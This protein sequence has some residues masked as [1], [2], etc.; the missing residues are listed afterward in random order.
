M[1]NSIPV[2]LSPRHGGLLA[3]ARFQLKTENTV[4]DPAA[5]Q[6]ILGGC[7][8]AFSMMSARTT[9]EI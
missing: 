5:C 1:E 4:A 8:N 3:A 6:R 2:L 7:K 9:P